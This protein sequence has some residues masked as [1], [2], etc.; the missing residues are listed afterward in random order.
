MSTPTTDELNEM[1]T[2]IAAEIEGA[3]D[4]GGDDALI[5]LCMNLRP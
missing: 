1:E 5:F 2:A 3:G 4:A